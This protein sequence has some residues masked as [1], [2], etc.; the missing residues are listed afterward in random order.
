MHVV[1]HG[2]SR[3]AKIKFGP[4][5][6]K[7]RIPSSDL[8]LS[9]VTGDVSTIRQKSIHSA[10]KLTKRL[11]LDEHRAYAVFVGMDGKLHRQQ[12]WFIMAPQ[13]IRLFTC[14]LK[15]SYL[16]DDTYIHYSFA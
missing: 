3:W 15:F 10:R 7:Q 5:R 11:L 2:T 9:H 1:V 12:T 6:N 16:E 14:A 13:T 8:P 4:P